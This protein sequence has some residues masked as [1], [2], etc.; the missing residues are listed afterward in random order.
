[1]SGGPEVRDGEREWRVFAYHAGWSE[2][3]STDKP[4]ALAVGNT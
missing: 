1:M 4:T 3:E 2:R